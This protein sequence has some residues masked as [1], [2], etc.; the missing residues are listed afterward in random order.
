M[1]L[2]YEFRRK[3]SFIKRRGIR[4][5]LEAA[6]ILKRKDDFIAWLSFVM[7]AEGQAHS[8]QKTAC[9]EKSKGPASINWHLTDVP[10]DS[11]CHFQLFELISELEKLKVHNRICLFDSRMYRNNEKALCDLLH[12]SYPCLDTNC[13]IVSDSKFAPVANIDI[14]TSWQTAYEVAALNSDSRKYYFLGQYEPFHHPSGSFQ[15]FCENAFDLDLNGI[16]IGS[17]IGSKVCEKHNM[18]FLELPLPQIRHAKAPKKQDD[19]KR[20]AFYANSADQTYNYIL[21]MLALGILC[22]EHPD[23]EI[24]YLGEAMGHRYSPAKKS[25]DFGLLKPGEYADA[26]SQCD[27]FMYLSVDNP[28]EIIPLAIS[29]G[30]IPVAIQGPNNQW[31]LN[32][33]NS[34][35]AE[36]NYREI[37]SVA[38][39]ALSHPEK[40]EAKRRYNAEVMK[41]ESIPSWH[42][43]AHKLKEHFFCG[44][45]SI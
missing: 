14:A 15:S 20:I 37:A 5:L 43:N 44:S 36:S 33:S 42:Q 12:D 40:I 22:K 7:K 17:F 18:S 3:V 27:L 31:L 32:D 2:K 35:L 25:Y 16:C 11:W 8:P 26:L 29:V 38:S 13:E 9:V 23:L 41:E 45:N 6:G 21:G 24:V 30:A 34:F 28:T 19:T 10:Y 4:G 39:D 1:D